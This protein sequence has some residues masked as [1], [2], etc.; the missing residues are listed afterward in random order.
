MPTGPITQKVIKLCQEIASDPQFQKYRSSVLDFIDN[1]DQN[2]EYFDLLDYQSQLEEKSEQGEE[3][4]PDQVEKLEE[5]GV[6]AFSNPAAVDFMHGQDALEQLQELVDNAISFV[7]EH[8]EAPSAK[9]LHEID[10]D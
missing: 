8:G 4:S 5:L 3:I 1:K 2:S 6:K 7:V 9:Y 10:E